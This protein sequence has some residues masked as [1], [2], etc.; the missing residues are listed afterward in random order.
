M[1][2]IEGLHHAFDEDEPV[3]AGIDLHI[4]RGGIRVILGGSGSGKSTILR[5]IL[6]L[7]KPQKGVIRV[8]GNDVVPMSEKELQKVRRDIGMVFQSAALFDSLTVRENVGY[9]FYEEGGLSEEEIEERVL[10]K[11]SFVNLEETL[12]MYPAELSGGMKKRVAI[13]RALATNPHLILFDEPTTGLDPITAH[14][15]TDH[16]L[17]LNRRWGVTSIVVTHDLKYAFKV[18]RKLSMIKDGKIIFDGTKEELLESKDSYVQQFL[19]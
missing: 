14:Q 8:D 2:Q 19:E 5:L 6:G 18:A 16:I 12:D 9:R 15:V 1:V 10:E 11:L 13:A 7:I 3:L 17:E 4:A